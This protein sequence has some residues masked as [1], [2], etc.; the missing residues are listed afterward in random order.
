MLKQSM[1]NGTSRS[2]R[3]LIPYASVAPMSNLKKSNDRRSLES[4]TNPSKKA[5]HF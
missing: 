2:F 4:E 1:K 5:S 3:S